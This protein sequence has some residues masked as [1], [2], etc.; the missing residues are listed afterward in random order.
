MHE[1]FDRVAQFAGCVN[2]TF[3]TGFDEMLFELPE[4]SLGRSEGGYQCLLQGIH[5]RQ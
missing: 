4:V 3:S 1:L 5:H 2:A